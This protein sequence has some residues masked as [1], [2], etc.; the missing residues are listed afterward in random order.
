MI[1]G[2]K[3]HRVMF[4]G[5]ANLLIGVS[6]LLVAKLVCPAYAIVRLRI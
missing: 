6:G 1:W 5:N 3:N 2:R 4:P